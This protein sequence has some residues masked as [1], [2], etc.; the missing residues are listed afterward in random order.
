MSA[1]AITVSK[2]LGTRIRVITITQSEVNNGVVMF[3]LPEPIFSMSVQL[4][5]TP[6][7]LTAALQCGN[8]GNSANLQA[9]PTAVAF[10]NTTGVLTVAR[11]DL[12]FRYYALDVS[13]SGAASDVVITIVVKLVF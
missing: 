12:G 9:M 7:G 1:P 4:T 5:G 2:K 3:E 10:A 11:A 13:A 6:N 8:D